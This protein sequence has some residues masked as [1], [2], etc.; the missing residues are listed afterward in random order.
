MPVD[1]GTLRS[2][3]CLSA[4]AA[5]SF[6][7][8]FADLY[9]R[10][11]RTTSRNA[12]IEAMADYF[13]AADPADAA[14]AVYFLSGE[15]P[16]RLL[17]STK[18]RTWA[19]EEAGIPDWLLEEAYT[20]VGDTAE[21]ITLLLPDGGGEA[22]RSLQYWVEERLLPLRPLDDDEKREAVTDIWRQLGRWERFVW[23]K[24]VTSGL[25][26]GVSQGL[27]VRGLEAY[28]EIDRDVLTAR[29][30]GDWTPS[31]E[32][33]EQLISTDTTDADRSR[34]YP[35]L[36]AH[37]IDEDPATALGPP[38][39]YLAEW[40]WDGIRSQ[41]IRR[42]GETYIWSRGEEII[43]DRYPEVADAAESLP[44][45]TVLD[46]EL[47]G[48]KDGEV[49]PFGMLQ[50][51]IGRETLPSDLREQVPISFMA[52]D[53]LESNGND[54]RP[55]PLA[56]RR[57]ELESLFRTEPLDS[58]LRLTEPFSFE[59]WDDLA[60]TR[61]RSREHK[62]EGLMLKRRAK[63]YEVGRPKGNWWKWKVEPFTLDGVLIYAQ[64]G[65][66]RR[67]TLHT[68]LSFALWDEDELVIFAK[69]YSG[70]TDDQF[71]ELDNWIRRHTVERFGP[72]RSVEP[73][74]VFEIA[75]EG[76]RR[77]NRH[78]CGVATRFPRI[79]RW[80]KDLSPNDADRLDDLQSLL[81]ELPAHV[82]TDDE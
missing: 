29:M 73:E 28:C 75:F 69:A 64:R 50:K 67:S 36:L 65:S 51:R 20:T 16:K 27:T 61:S 32:F 15:R 41:I 58:H 79:K 55:E 49:L 38:A 39:D 80:R 1:A 2:S 31:A 63:C 72:V 8:D 26:V 14:W 10:L 82:D 30:M 21:T 5:R 9:R 66:G 53:L 24:L 23:N 18:M 77:S 48:W 71:Q 13:D 78:K 4:S 59:T 62:T 35:F 54:L 19:A 33:F 43:T 46:G 17:S 81:P 11:D 34:P 45:G 57:S 68:D 22:D 76:V 6:M 44:D 60:E 70:L 42:G 74:H 25:R 3:P 56:T 7:Q 37:A 52:F 12:K 40:K 47:L